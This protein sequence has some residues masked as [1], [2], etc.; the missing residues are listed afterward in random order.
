[1]VD[2][3]HLLAHRK[4]SGK[5]SWHRV[6][7][8]VPYR[9]RYPG[10]RGS[11][12]CNKGHLAHRSSSVRVAGLSVTLDHILPAEQSRAASSSNDFP[13]DGYQPAAG[14]AL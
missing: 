8:W 4:D 5:S 2:V 7:F 11:A 3:Q 6:N 14:L 10:L 13:K 9:S 12:L 1:M